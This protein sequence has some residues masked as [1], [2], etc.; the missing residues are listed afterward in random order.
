MDEVVKEIILEEENEGMSCTDITIIPKIK[1]GRKPKS[2]PI[3]QAKAIRAR[4]PT[5]SYRTIAKELGCGISYQTV[6][7]R[8]KE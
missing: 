6:R 8:L 1:K 5:P 3:E 2:F 7:R 4:V